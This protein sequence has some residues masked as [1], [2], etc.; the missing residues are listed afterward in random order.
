MSAR[1]QARRVSV[2]GKSFVYTDHVCFET[3]SDA[4]WVL[5]TSIGSENLYF[6]FKTDTGE[7]LAGYCKCL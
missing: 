5:I 2:N 6:N 4:G 1:R 7:E 3:L